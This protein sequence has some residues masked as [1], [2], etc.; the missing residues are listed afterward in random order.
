MFG[1]LVPVVGFGELS[2]VGAAIIR[3]AIARVNT[4]HTRFTRELRLCCCGV[5]ITNSFSA[6]YCFGD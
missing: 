2:A 1:G 3:V 4:L 5:V 6:A